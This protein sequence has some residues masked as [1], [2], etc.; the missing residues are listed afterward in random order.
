MLRGGGVLPIHSVIARE[1]SE[2][3]AGEVLK[4][5]TILPL[6]YQ[7]LCGKMQ[8]G[9]K[10]STFFVSFSKGKVYSFCKLGP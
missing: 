2:A 7:A 6:I 10:K 3:A 9:L 5:G 8:K 1:G 4:E